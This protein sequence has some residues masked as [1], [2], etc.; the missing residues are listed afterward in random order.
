MKTKI[1][2]IIH[3]SGSSLLMQIVEFIGQHNEGKLNV[4]PAFVDAVGAIKAAD[5]PSLFKD[6]K[7]VHDKFN[8]ND[9]AYVSMDK[10]F[11][12]FITLTWKEV[13]EELTEKEKD[14]LTQNELS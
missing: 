7:V 9:V 14:L 5:L 12:P 8:G 11:D 4:T 13:P 1:E 10:E 2:V 6:T 3:K